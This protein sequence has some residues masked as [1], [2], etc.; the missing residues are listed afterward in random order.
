M[1]VRFEYRNRETRFATQLF[2][3]IGR[4][5]P[6]G[7]TLE[8]SDPDSRFDKSQITSRGSWTSFLYRWG[9][10]AGKPNE[11]QYPNADKQNEPFQLSSHASLEVGFQ[12]SRVTSD[13]GLILVRVLAER[14]RFGE[15]ILLPL[16]LNVGGYKHRPSGAAER[17]REVVA[18][19]FAAA[20]LSRWPLPWIPVTPDSILQLLLYIAF[21]HSYFALPHLS[22]GG[23]WLAF[24]WS[25]TIEE[26]FH[27]VSPHLAH[28]FDQ[29]ELLLGHPAT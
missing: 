18:A 1:L 11:R 12:G 10:N 7:R 6:Q 21:N 5:D 3:F 22:L 24:T 16:W 9:W 19:E 20:I 14:L 23:Y 25:L 2:T 13:G 26:Q 4:A 29:R 17:D 15:P 28:F 8:H 27:L